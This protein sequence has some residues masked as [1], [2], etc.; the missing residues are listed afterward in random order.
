[1]VRGRDCI[2]INFKSM[3]VSTGILIILAVMLPVLG[4]G[5]DSQGIE[6]YQKTIIV[7]SQVAT[8]DFTWS[9]QNFAGFYYGL[10]EDAG[11]ELLTATLSNG[12]FSGSH[13]YGLSYQTTSQEIPFQ[14]K[15]W[16]SYYVM[17]FLGEKCFAGY[18][19][20]LD[21]EE[22][23]LF[24]KSTDRSALAKGQLLKVLIDD[25]T[26]K[27]ITTDTPLKLQDGYELAIKS[28][29]IDGNNAYL[30]LTKN[31]DVVDSKIVYPSRD[32]ATLAD[33]TYYYRNSQVGD[34]K[35]LV[36]I[37]VHFK[38]AFKGADQNLATIDGVFQISDS[39]ISIAEGTSFEKMTVSSVTSD[40]ILMDNRDN[41]ITLSK[42][43]DVR[44]AGDI[45]LRTADQNIVDD[46]SSLRYCLYREIDSPGEYDV[47]G[48]VS[49]GDYVWTPQNFAGFYYD[50]DHDAGAETLTAA[51]SDKTLAGDFPYGM[52]YSTTAQEVPF[53]FQ[54]W[55]SYYVIGFLG[56]KCF[57][58]YTEGRAPGKAYLFDKSVDRNALAKEQLLKILA[59]DDTERT[60]TTHK[61]LKLE[62]GY[63]LAIR[64]VSA[65]GNNV[66]LELT[67]DGDVVDS[68]VVYPSKED[69]TL[70]D[71]TYC[72]KNP[73]VG[74]QKGLVTIAVHFKN[75]FRGA[76]QNLATINE[77]WQIS[78]MP[79]IVKADTQYG[80][81][82]ID[83][84][85]ADNGFIA[86]NNRDHPITLS[87]NRDTLLMGDISIQTA[88]SDS[89][90]YY[91]CRHEEIINA[92]SNEAEAGPESAPSR[93]GAIA[94]S[95][96]KQSPGIN[97]N[98]RSGNDGQD[99]EHP[100]SAV[101]IDA[102]KPTVITSTC[103]DVDG[104]VSAEVG[105]EVRNAG[106][107]LSVPPGAVPEDTEVLVRR[108]TGE[109]PA[110]E[111]PESKAS[112][113]VV[114]SDTFD[115]G[116]D[117]I[118]FSKPVSITLP[119]REDLLPE[120]TDERDIQFGYFDGMGWKAI[121]G[122]VD[123]EK[124]TASIDLNEFPGVL[125]ELFVGAVIVGAYYVVAKKIAGHV[126]G[127]LITS[128]EADKYV[129]PNDPVVLANSKRAILRGVKTNEELT[130]KDPKLG[131]MLQR[132]NG[133]AQLVYVN[134][135]GEKNQ[136]KYPQDVEAGD[137]GK[138][139]PRDYLTT[140]NYEGDCVDITNAG[141]SIFSANGIPAKGSGGYIKYVDKPDK[142]PHAWGEVVID[143]KV[144]LLDENGKIAPLED[145]M[146]RI[147]LERGSTS[148]SRYRMWDDK[149]ITKYDPEWF[150][151]YLT[152]NA[153]LKIEQLGPSCCAGSDCI[154]LTTTQVPSSAKFDW[155][156]DEGESQEFDNANEGSQIHN[157]W[158]TAGEHTAYLTVTAPGFQGQ[159][160]GTIKVDNCKSWE[161][162]ARENQEN[163]GH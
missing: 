41:P 13:P 159:G 107:I 12:E 54:D 127:D 139:M 101:R 63:E 160:T 152:T 95:K 22:A 51:L 7:N 75:A 52:I 91:I 19:E 9:P 144:Y 1:M 119:Y 83:T 25:D 94:P 128:G 66:Y 77:V 70:A 46:T 82:T 140:R 32:A 39:P 59:E 123:T 29:D 50:L 2:R 125:L 85:D 49:T 74:D 38:N 104:V 148:D 109:P 18:A 20:W 60:I 131:E 71:K 10:D 68:R 81:M 136:Q 61:P 72:Y 36:T 24:S 99:L 154:V 47:R 33:K 17:G 37:A 55:G 90:R 142:F 79:F 78:D 155:S 133:E 110:G 11:T 8:G 120:G 121:G 30:E 96:T 16:G 157:T 124:N 53:Q 21:S 64:S 149:G 48:S 156:F 65:D 56:E 100:V 147:G 158:Y 116:P 130:L 112:S 113:A 122:I 163:Q 132:N 141:V 69:A 67:K 31:G 118:K 84:I 108:L 57:A 6:P 114:V 134:E 80:K 45:R 14:F 3:L 137:F 62:E 15:D 151:K 42:N 103:E 93:G 92:G 106:A 111:V 150:K 58:G 126:E 97:G 138:I 44:L 40:Q 87:K 27:T 23:Y 135:N 88:N 4:L 117:G 161:D 146:K 162:V 26:E 28:I 35:R 105:G 73:K 153:N 34:Q 43:K 102:V 115:F 145:A 86:M 129:T 76:D 5:S 143:K 98:N 89:L